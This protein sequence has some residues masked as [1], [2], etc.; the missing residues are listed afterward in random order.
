[1]NRV[2]VFFG[3]LAVIAFPFAQA[4]TNNSDFK[5]ALPEHRGQLQWFAEGTQGLESSAKPNEHEIGIGGSED[6]GRPTF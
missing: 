6:S 4:Q 1:M 3:V 2:G 5:L